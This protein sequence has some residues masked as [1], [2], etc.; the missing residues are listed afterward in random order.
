[1]TLIDY[2]ARA[3]LF[4][5][6]DRSTALAQGPRDFRTLAQALRFAFEQA[7]PVSLHGASLR[8]GEKTFE[9]DEMRWLYQSPA[10][11][12]PRPVAM[13]PRRKRRMPFY[14]ASFANAA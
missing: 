1:M 13:A 3:E 10:Y 14:G 11:P 2:T 7:A 12:L 5:G 9:R 4:L 8:V 6:S